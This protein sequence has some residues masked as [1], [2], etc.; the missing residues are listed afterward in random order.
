MVDFPQTVAIPSTASYAPPMVDF[1]PKTPS[2]TSTRLCRRW[3]TPCTV[4]P[5]RS[6]SGVRGSGACARSTGS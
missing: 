2:A 6:V 1:S 3:V 4:T 5:T